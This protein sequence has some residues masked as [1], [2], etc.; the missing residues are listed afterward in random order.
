MTVVTLCPCNSKNNFNECCRPIIE[1][2]IVADSPEKL[3]RSRYS[4]YFI[5][6]A[7]YIYNT[8]AKS[9]REKQSVAEIAEWANQCKWLRLEILATSSI[10]NISNVVDVKNAKDLP[11]VEFSAYYLFES[12]L[13]QLT[14]KSRF[15]KK[16]NHWFYLD[17]DITAN[18]ELPLPKRNDLCP[19]FSQIK[20]KRCCGNS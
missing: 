18:K 1:Q 14:E 4:A 16:D 17:G 9:S 10:T 8:Y 6:N 20:F 7:E 11:T 5:K 12:K 3:M 2:K 15:I 13:C 19:C